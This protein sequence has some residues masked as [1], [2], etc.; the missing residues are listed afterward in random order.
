MIVM[1]RETDTQK[2]REI[3]ALEGIDYSED[4]KLFA[5]KDKDEL[6][7]YSLFSLTDKLTIINI[8]TPQILW[9]SIGDGLFRATLNCAVENGV[10]SAKIEKALLKKLSGNVIPTEK[11][12]ESIDDC[13][14]FLLSIKRCGG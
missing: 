7:G 1:T 12:T 13:E 9:N 4:I 5:A 14:E 2:V 8:S 11:V 6:L 10:R 3:C